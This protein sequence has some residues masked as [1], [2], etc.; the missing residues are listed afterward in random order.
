MT[1]IHILSKGKVV[2]KIIGGN[3]AEHRAHIRSRLFNS[4]SELLTD[5]GFESLTMAE[6]A[7][8][9]EVGRTAV[10]NHFPDKESLLLAFITEQTRRYAAD[11]QQSLA[12]VSDPIERIRIYV[13]E[14][15]RLNSSYHMNTSMELRHTVTSDTAMELSAHAV[16]V[17]DILRSILR[18]AMQQGAIVEQRTEPLVHLIHAT[19]ASG[20]RANEPHEYAGTIAATE[21]FIL[22][23]LGAQV[24]PTSRE[25]Y[26][27]LVQLA[28]EDLKNAPQQRRSPSLCPVAH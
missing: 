22:R 24:E 15:L 26:L 21:E 17:E 27:E 16:I 13:R 19:L 23:G 20:I 3:L 6:I 2:P 8:K 9:A 5:K 1:I 7:A 18:D 14:Q 12:G 10:Y 4:L 28:A 25:H 11:I